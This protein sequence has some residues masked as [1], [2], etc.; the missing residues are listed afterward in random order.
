M[1]SNNYFPESVYDFLGLLLSEVLQSVKELTSTLSSISTG[2]I[3]ELHSRFSKEKGRFGRIGEK[4]QS[5][6]DRLAVIL[7][8]GQSVMNTETMAQSSD[9]PKLSA[10]QNEFR[11]LST[12]R[13]SKF[14]KCKKWF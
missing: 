3:H 1:K 6:E 4:S 14:R 9:D 7:S 8:A 5:T 11:L 10:K 2:G 12:Q 13:N